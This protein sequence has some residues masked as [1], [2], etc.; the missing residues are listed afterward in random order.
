[1][2]PKMGLRVSSC[3]H[4]AFSA[5]DCHE[6][7]GRFWPVSDHCSG[8]PSLSSHTRR[9]CH[10]HH[11]YLQPSVLEQRK[12]SRTEGPAPPERYL[13]NPGEAANRREK[14]RSSALRFSHRQQAASLRFNQAPCARRCPWRKP[15]ITSHGDAAENA[16]ASAVRDH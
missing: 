13:G 12:I 1:M 4:N 3:F 2:P 8:Q 10:E 15:V 6:I 16:A 5:V 7:S 9:T 11:C 14:S